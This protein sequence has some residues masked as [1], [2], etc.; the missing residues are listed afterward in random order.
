MTKIDKVRAAL[1]ALHKSCKGRMAFNTAKLY[2][3]ALSELDGCVI[4]PVE[5]TAE[6]GDKYRLI[7]EFFEE[8]CVRGE[9]D[10]E[11]IKVPVTWTTIK[12]LHRAMIAP[13]V[14]GEKI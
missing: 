6:R 11:T 5:L 3:E 1:E 10:Y 13:Y 7:G 12:N 4:V 9:Y 14:N 2:E 8:Y